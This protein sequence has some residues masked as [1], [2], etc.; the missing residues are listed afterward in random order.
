MTDAMSL[1]SSYRLTIFI[2]SLK[3]FRRSPLFKTHHLNFDRRHAI[4]TNS[5]S[6]YVLHQTVSSIYAVLS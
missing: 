2:V 3:F 4:V 6:S 5:I 1:L